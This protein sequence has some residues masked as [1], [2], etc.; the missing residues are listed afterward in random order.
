MIDEELGCIKKFDSWNEHEQ[1]EFVKEL[2][3]RMAF[4]QQEKVNSFLEPILQRDF[5][6]ELANRGLDNIACYILSSLIPYFTIYIQI[7]II[8]HSFTEYFVIIALIYMYAHSA[9]KFRPV[10]RWIKSVRRLSEH[11]YRTHNCGE[12]RYKHI[13][14]TVK[15][16]G[17]LQK[18]RI[19]T[20]S[21]V[22]PLFIPIQDMYGVTQAVTK[23]PT[24][25]KI[26]KQTPIDSIVSIEGIVIERISPNPNLRT[27]QIEIVVNK[28]EILNQCENLHYTTKSHSKNVSH[29]LANHT[30]YLYLRRQQNIEVLKKRS[31]FIHFL[32]NYLHIKHNFI[33]IETPILSKK[34]PEG[35]K[36]FIVP[37]SNLKRQF[38]TLSQ[39]PQQYKQLLMVS[40][41]DKYFQIAKCFR[42]EIH[43][44]QR[45]IEFSQLDL[46][47]AFVTQ[48]DVINLIE[49]MVCQ[50]IENI[51]PKSALLERPFPRLTYQA[52]M[53]QY[54]TD[55]PDLRSAGT[56]DKLA[57]AWIQDFPLFTK[58]TQGVIMSTHHPFTTHH[59]DDADLIYS[60]PLRARGQSYDLVLNGVEVGGGS[61]RV[62][63]AALQKHIIENIL[64]ED[65]SHLQH[66]ITALGHGCPPHGGFALGLDRILMI[67]LGRLNANDV[68]AF[69]K[70]SAGRDNTVG[71]PGNLSQAEL[72]EY[73]LCFKS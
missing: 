66:L 16:A 42:D 63:Q 56:K 57:F 10:Y 7:E 67:L 17:W 69:P 27:G 28:I 52:A 72:S 11:L 22:I 6:S 24:L 68:I 55:K 45:Q 41:I 59:I 1:I 23:E 21:D 58:T 70:S 61:I 36:E 38:Y 30:R 60:D 62:H 37:S 4:H 43:T 2:I 25:K 18:P 54:N 8:H 35:A 9:V 34:S 47:M 49:E 46:E 50:A 53:K 12:L 20:N 32:S 15:V 26:V 65:S 3:S 5:I 71:S 31:E 64:K 39:S 48:D 29:C 51:C 19:I 73:E 40:S 33:E 14:Q 44:A 13:G